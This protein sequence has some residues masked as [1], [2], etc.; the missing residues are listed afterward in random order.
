MHYI[1]E[2]NEFYEINTSDFAYHV[3]SKDNLNSIMKL[4]LEPRVPEDYG[5]DGDI[6]GVYLFKTKDDVENALDNW[7]GERIDEIEEES[8]KD[9]NEV[10]LK[11]DIKGLEEYLIDSVEYEWTCT[12]TIDPSRITIVEL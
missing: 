4:G 12:T 9:Y 11:V 7:L 8:G 6:K 5:S 1:L 3:T 2:Y 10:I